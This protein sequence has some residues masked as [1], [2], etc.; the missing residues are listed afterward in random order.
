MDVLYILGD[1][2]KWEN[3]E[4]IYSIRTLAKHCRFDRIFITGSAH[5]KIKDVVFTPVKDLQGLFAFNN[6][7]KI[8]ETIKRTDIS[9][10]FLLMYDDI[11]FTKN[12]DIEQYPYYTRPE[13]LIRE[14]NKKY[15]MAIN[16]TGVWLK[17]NGYPTKNYCVH[18]PI[19]YNREKFLRLDRFSDE[20]R[21]GFLM[22]PRSLYGNMNSLPSIEVP[23][24]KVRKMEEFEKI[25]ESF[26]CFSTNNGVLSEG[27]GKW[28]SDNYSEKTRFEI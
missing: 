10:D 3:R 28:L 13:S 22:S 25:K 14:P 2:S 17:E 21:N 24:N 16:N 23:D 19:I 15:N 6:L 20:M 18:C 27:V 12:T 4:I 26:N 11:F 8:L 9:D 1:G 7:N 5:E